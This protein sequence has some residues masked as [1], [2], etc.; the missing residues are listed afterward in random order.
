MII[1]CDKCSAKFTVPSAAIPLEGRTVKCSKCDHRWKQL[2]LEDGADLSDV[3]PAPEEEA[4]IPKGSNLPSTDMRPEPVPQELKISLIALLVISGI[5]I[6]LG[7]Q[8]SLGK[9]GLKPLYSL[10]G[11]HNTHEL[12]LTDVS[13]E[14]TREDNKFTVT[15]T[16]ALTN[17]SA[18]HSLHAQDLH[19]SLRTERNNML[20]E[21]THAVE[22][23]TLLPGES[24]PINAEINNISGSTKV[25]V[26]DV[27]NW[28]ELSFR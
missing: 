20:G 8:A 5:F 16:A 23:E 15:L 26:L 28:M 19:L 14:I 24:I 4:P 18:D 21:L 25:L 9:M 12:T 7:H 6:L 13:A 3:T 17:E 10:L 1:V 11:M 2:P 22:G 27:G